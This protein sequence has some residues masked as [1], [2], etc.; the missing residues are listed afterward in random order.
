MNE[1]FKVHRSN[2]MR[3]FYVKKK[4]KKRSLNISIKKEVVFQTF[5]EVLNIC[6]PTL[7]RKV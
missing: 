2:I 5:F 3:L 7:P 6:V 1:A 4:E